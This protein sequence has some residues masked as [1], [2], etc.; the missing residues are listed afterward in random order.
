M[1]AVVRKA[2]DEDAPAVYA[3]ERECSSHPWTEEQILEE[4]R[5]AQAY[6]CVCEAEGEVTGFATMQTA[7][8]F[9]HINEL[10]VLPAF[11]R[12]GYA[13]MIMQ[14]LFREG[15]DRGCEMI[16]LEVRKSNTAARNLYGSLGFSDAGTRKRFYRD[17]EEDAVVMIKEL[18]EEKI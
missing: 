11:R 3:V 14:D 6:T 10:G 7:A 15:L 2:L 4:I 13:R 1:N 12:R 5:F 17:P 8:E 18:K 9:A 16:S